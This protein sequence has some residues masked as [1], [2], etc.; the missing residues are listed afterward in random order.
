MKCLID[1]SIY[2]PDLDTISMVQSM[3]QVALGNNKSDE[4]NDA[5][6]RGMYIIALYE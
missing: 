4:S 6:S 2:L 1:S 3:H 5:L